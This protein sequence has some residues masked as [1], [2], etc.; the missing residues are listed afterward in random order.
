MG[1]AATLAAAWLALSPPA[2]ARATPLLERVHAGGLVDLTAKVN[3]E[4]TVTNID[5][6]GY[7]NYST[8]ALR[9]NFD[10]Q[11]SDKT[12]VFT[13]I[14]AP[15]GFRFG[16]YGAYVRFRDLGGSRV[17]LQ[18]GKMPS[19]FGGYSSHAYGASRPLISYPLIYQYHTV[20]ASN[21]IP[22]SADEI[23][24]WKEERLTDPSFGQVTNDAGR[25]PLP[26][27][28]DRCWDTGVELFTSTERLEA[29]L[30]VTIGTL[31]NP[32]TEDANSGK[33]VV[34]RLAFIAGRGTRV[35]ISAAYGPYLDE[36][37]VCYGEGAEGDTAEAFEPDVDEYGE[38]SLG[39]DLEWGMRHVEL[40]VEGVAKRWE[41]PW[42]AEDLWSTGYHTELKYTLWPGLYAA[43]AYG[44]LLFGEVE[45]SDGV[46]EKW[47]YPIR[48]IETGVGYFLNER[49]LLR[50]TVQWNE[51]YGFDDDD[52]EGPLPALQLEAAF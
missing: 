17:S 42:I 9:L 16:L 10:F 12:T 44:E 6:D 22:S 24:A 25:V 5:N 11:V 20:V 14:F 38:L 21:F 50:A 4:R 52:L 47:D 35:G 1:A 46:M 39:A 51:L 34:G 37:T 30:G 45:R 48:R 33:Q 13:E 3:R 15:G 8:L 41:S 27:L 49:T 40:Y 28:Y 43:A 31:S 7:S 29:S 26:P 23:L 32:L 36:C 19:A 2:P 18:A